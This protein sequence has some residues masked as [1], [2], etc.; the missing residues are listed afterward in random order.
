MPS[1]FPIRPSPISNCT[2][3]SIFLSLSLSLL[4]VS[5]AIP[6]RDRIW[7]QF[8]N[9]IILSIR[10]HAWRSSPRRTRSQSSRTSLS[11]WLI[12]RPRMRVYKHSAASS[13]TPA[14]IWRTGYETIESSA[15]WRCSCRTLAARNPVC[16]VANRGVW[17]EQR[18]RRTRADNWKIG[19][20]RFRC[21]FVH[22]VY[23]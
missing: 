6:H 1:Q 13:R 19:K 3:I 5:M 2:P 16:D 10:R 8:R 4:D 15:W 11:N 23:T 18:G 21:D 20:R 12:D 14:R 17:C 9:A 7:M 22:R